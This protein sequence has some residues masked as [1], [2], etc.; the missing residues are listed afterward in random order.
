MAVTE[1]G[2]IVG[3]VIPGTA[4]ITQALYMT[5]EQARKPATGVYDAP[6]FFSL[7]VAWSVLVSVCLIFT[8][9]VV[10]HFRFDVIFYSTSERACFM[11]QTITAPGTDEIYPTDRCPM[12]KVFGL[13]GKYSNAIEHG[14]LFYALAV[15]SLSVIYWHKCGGGAKCRFPVFF[16]DLLLA[17]AYYAEGLIFELHSSTHAKCT[18]SDENCKFE[19]KYLAGRN[20]LNSLLHTMIQWM[21][22]WTSLAIVAAVVLNA[23]MSRKA[24]QKTQLV[25]ACKLWYFSMV[26]AQGL[27][28]YYLSIIGR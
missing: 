25:L 9:F 18:D 14:A 19:K 16:P 27:W 7:R 8:G 5:L 17:A 10:S 2:N 28:M 12:G 11:S 21:T 13:F 4:L 6:L 24:E 1:W 15:A 3:H 26:L 20:T 22:N 23:V